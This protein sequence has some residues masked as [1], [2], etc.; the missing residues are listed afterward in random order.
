M[1]IEL[2]NE[3]DMPH[4]T[5]PV[6]CRKTNNGW[7]GKGTLDIGEF[8]GEWKAVT[9]G[10]DFQADPKSKAR[11]LISLTNKDRASMENRGYTAEIEMTREEVE[12]MYKGNAH[13]VAK[14]LNVM[15]EE[16]FHDSRMGG[17]SD[18]IEPVLC[19]EVSVNGVSPSEM[20]KA[21]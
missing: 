2:K 19:G 6:A 13:T 3:N 16:P 15:F 14:A 8:H 10:I 21:A 4:G 20:K 1:A 9:N 5:F 7:N 17:G 12:D 11:I 18:K